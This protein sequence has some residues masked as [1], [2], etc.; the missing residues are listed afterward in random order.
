MTDACI[1]AGQL[2][3]AKNVGVHKSLRLIID[4]PQ[5]KAMEVIEKL[6]WPTM[7]TPI[8]VAI[9]RLAQPGTASEPAAPRAETPPAG[10]PT[11]P[12]P[13]GAFPLPQKV[14]AMCADVR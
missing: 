9:A 14:G 6:G 2:V 12:T 11:L 3:D 5:E 1:I 4:V 8:P 10:S 13:R 7:A